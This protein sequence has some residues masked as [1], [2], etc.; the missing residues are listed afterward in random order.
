VSAPEGASLHPLFLK[1]AGTGFADKFVPT[2]VLSAKAGYV[3][4]YLRGCFGDGYVEN[5]GSICWKMKN[6]KL[7]SQLAYLLGLVGIIPSIGKDG[8]TLFVSG[9]SE[10]EN[11]LPVIL[12]QDDRTFML[13]RLECIKTSSYLMPKAF[14]IVA[15][16][17]IGL[18]Q[19]IG[20][21]NY[22]DL[23]SR[24]TYR[25]LCEVRARGTEGGINRQ[26]AILA[27]EHIL[28]CK[29]RLGSESTVDLA[30]RVLSL[31]KSDIAFDPVNAIEKKEGV[32]EYV[33][34]LSVPSVERFI[35]GRSGLLLHNSAGAA[36][37]RELTT[38]SAVWLGVWATD[39]IKHR[40]P[41]D[42]LTEVDIKRLYELKAD[43][44]YTDKMW[45]DELDTFL[46]IK[47]KSEQE[48]FARYGLTYIV[49]KYLPEKLQLM[50]KA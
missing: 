45:H 28:S 41:S 32:D 12:H 11:A 14:P 9:K 19:E 10:L 24:Y 30:K 18:R 4:E 17:L 13:Q 6:P 43:P 50:K 7:I 22:H 23:R 8:C 49:D 38:P 16:G 31:A 48:A 35:G 5:R 36:H 27:L 44:R 20:R 37:L 26:H 33:Y 42:K 3:M 2:A 40:L 39:I 15:S 34:D 1:L 29:K 46:R 47:K 25:R 21:H